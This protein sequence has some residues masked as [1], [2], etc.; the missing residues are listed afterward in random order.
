MDRGRGSAMDGGK[1]SRSRE[2]IKGQAGQ[3]VGRP[4]PATG[5]WGRGSVQRNTPHGS[6]RRPGS[7]NG[8]LGSGECAAHEKGP[9]T[10]RRSAAQTRRRAEN[11]VEEFKRQWTRTTPRE[12]HP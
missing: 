5:S 7:C 10:A 11:L 3:G 1:W 8:F 12:W 9:Q 4:S 6:G 2:A